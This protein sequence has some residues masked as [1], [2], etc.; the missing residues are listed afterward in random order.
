MSSKE[1]PTPSVPSAPAPP[2]PAP[3]A[4]PLAAEPP[5]QAHAFPPAPAEDAQP[6]EE[7][8]LTAAVPPAAAVRLNVARRLWLATVELQGVRRTRL[9]FFGV[10]GFAQVVAWIV[11]LALTFHSP[12]DRPLATYLVMTVVRI[13]LGYPCAYWL[14]IAPARPNPR[15]DSP[16]VREA[17]ERN[18]YVG[19]YAIDRRVRLL[20]DCVSVYSLAVFVLGNIWTITSDTCAETSPTLYRSAVAALVFSWIWTAELLLWLVLVVFALPFL[21]IAMRFFGVG[22]AK[23]EI[24][25]LSKTDIDSLPKRVFVGTLP[26][27]EETPDT[28]VE[29]CDTPTATP[30]R[31][32][33]PSPPTA[34]SSPTRPPHRRQFWRLWRRGKASSSEAGKAGGDG[35]GAG[36]FV[37]FPPGVEPVLVP[38]SQAACAICLCEYELPPL[39]SAGA[40]AAHGWEPEL[41]GLLPCKHCFHV[42]C[43]RDWLVVS[44]R[45]PLCQRA[46][47]EPKTRRGRKGLAPPNPPSGSGTGGGGGAADR[48]SSGDGAGAGGS[49][50]GPSAAERV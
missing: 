45:C 38:V 6:D 26:D 21:L 31:A 34:S 2:P 16:E 24:G 20:N 9:A 46:V 22:Q 47:N 8:E 39:R 3:P 41:L 36:E 25:G 18:R 7:R 27:T 5:P 48:D 19:S 29:P 43:L 1:S 10:L 35:T 12:C 4:S 13:A 42:E 50:G 14:T 44:G 28:A 15:R 40:E 33:A 49:D 32:P 11:V 17:A 23:H 37:P 30:T